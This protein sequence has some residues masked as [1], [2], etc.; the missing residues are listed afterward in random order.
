MGMTLRAESDDGA[1][2]RAQELKIRVSVR[3][4]PHGHD[5]GRERRGIVSSP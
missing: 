5:K 2:F 1:R 4:D 3:I